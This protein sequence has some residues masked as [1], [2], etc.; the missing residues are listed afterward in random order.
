MASELQKSLNKILRSNW[1]P[2]LWIV[3]ILAVT[4]VPLEATDEVPPIFCVLCGDGA[5]ADGVLNAALFLPLGVALSVAGWRSWSALGLAALLS[6]G[7][8]TAQVMI[9]GRD[10]SLSDVLFN[11]LGTALGIALA[12][13]ASTWWRPPRRLAQLLSICGSIGTVSVLALTGVLLDPSF[14]NATYYGGWTPRFGHL[15]WYGGRLLEASVNGLEIPSGV[16]ARSA[17]LRQLLLSGATINLRARAGTRPAGLAPLLTIHDRYQREILLLGADGDDFVYR[18]RTRAVAYG[19][20]GPEIRVDGALR[21]L[22]SSDPLSILV[23]PA[24]SGYCI[25]VNAIAH[26]DRGYTVGVGWAM[27]LGGRG[28]ASW[29]QSVLNVLW[30]AILFFPPG[31]WVRS[32]RLFLATTVLSLGSLLILP[33]AVGL[34]PTPGVE[35]LGASVGFLSGWFSSPRHGPSPRWGTGSF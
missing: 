11:V 7:V 16:V 4:L 19:L 13:S 28:L 5:L 18:Y 27:L 26:C 2:T 6:G 20:V 24:T 3:V 22:A 10:P 32:G 15:Q 1:L 30:L 31:L 8:E 33:Q 25:R 14:P 34:L 29:H 12:W 9:P 17:E 23:R 35:L 21:G